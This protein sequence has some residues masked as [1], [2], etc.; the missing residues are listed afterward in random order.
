MLKGTHPDRQGL[1]VT[2]GGAKSM[3]KKVLIVD[4]AKVIRDILK[5]IFTAMGHIVVGEATTGKEA[6]EMYD[7]LKPDLVTMD[8]VMPELNGIQTLKQIMEKDSNANII[9]IS[10]L[11]HESLVM[12]AL[13]IGAKDFIVKPFK[14]EEV[15]KVVSKYI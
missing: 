4:D 6:L 5:D 11:G 2:N 15:V 9:V 3:G 14:K 12:E 1:T 10:A 13:K 7:R 8:I